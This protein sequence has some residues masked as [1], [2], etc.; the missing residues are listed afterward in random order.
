MTLG[1]LG[2]FNYNHRRPKLTMQGVI[3]FFKSLFEHTA[4]RDLFNADV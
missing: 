1:T 3:T 2:S 4:K